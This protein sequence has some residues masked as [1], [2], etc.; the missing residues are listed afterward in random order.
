MR[1]SL[2]IIYGVAIAAVANAAELSPPMRAGLD[3]AVAALTDH[4]NTAELEH[5]DRPQVQLSGPAGEPYLARATYRQVTPGYGVVRFNADGP[6]ATVRVRATEFEKRATNLQ[7]E[8]PAR[9]IAR[10][11]WHETP[12]GYL[13]DF[14]L[15]WDGTR[16]QQV[17]SEVSRPVLGNIG[18]DEL[19]PAPKDRER[20]R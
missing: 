18:A 8:D 15:R 4:F 14:T 19:K 9:S 3:A 1:N 12:R 10:A 16:W 6:V 7:G 20:A 5:R 13:L 11:A 2:V 17:G